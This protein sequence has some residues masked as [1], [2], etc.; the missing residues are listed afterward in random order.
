[1]M[2]AVMSYL[3]V[4]SGG[5]ILGF[6][7]GLAAKKIGKYLLMFAGVYFASLIYLQYQGLITINSNL[8]DS[9]NGIVGFF[10]QRIDTVWAAAAIS[11][12]AIGAFAAGLYFG[13]R[14]S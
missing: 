9:V 2:S 14:K 3:P 6:G 11:L 1:M 8:G 13:T 12:P 7:V 10:G 4:M 5:A